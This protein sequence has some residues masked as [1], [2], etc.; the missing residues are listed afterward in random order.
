MAFD[1]LANKPTAAIALQTATWAEM[2][3]DASNILIVYIA[4]SPPYS[5]NPTR[6]V[7]SLSGVVKDQGYFIYAKI[8]LD[9]SAYFVPPL[10]DDLKSWVIANF[11]GINH[12]HPISDIIDLQQDLDNLKITETFTTTTDY[13]YTLSAN[14]VLL[15]IIIDSSATYNLNIGKT[16]NGNEILDSEA[17]TANVPDTISTL[18]YAK[19]NTSIYFSGITGSTKF[20]LLKTIT[21]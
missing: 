9:V 4:D 1:I 14:S 10:D 11:A 8:D 19:A 21:P 15:G 13:T 12:T 16:A 2:G 20:I 7:N 6:L 18:I 5:W 17:I 3:L